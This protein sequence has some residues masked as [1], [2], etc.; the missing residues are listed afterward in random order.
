MDYPEFNESHVL[1]S[2]TNGNDHVKT[3]MKLGNQYG[4]GVQSEPV[5]LLTHVLVANKLTELS[6]VHNIVLVLEHC[7][8]VVVYIQIVGC[9]ENRHD[10]GETSCP[11]LPVH[12]VASILGLVCTD[13][14][15]KVVLFEESA[16]GWVG[17]EV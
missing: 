1:F 15:Q 6:N 11:C 4:W 5:S 8:L 14:G 3:S 9:T 7:S 13:N 17:K 16:G 10:T 2:P 12:S